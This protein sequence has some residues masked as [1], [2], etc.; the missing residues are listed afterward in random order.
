MA[1]Q[2]VWTLNG[3][4]GTLLLE[5]IGRNE[6]QVGLFS[7]ATRAG[8]LVLIPL[9]ALI[10]T[11]LPRLGP[12]AEGAEN[13][14]ARQKLYGH[15]TRQLTLFSVIVAL[16][17]I[18]F[19]E[20]VLGLFGSD[21]RTAGALLILTGISYLVTGCVGIAALFLQF[22]GHE[23]FSLSVVIGSTLLDVL[24]CLIL[25]PRFEAGGAATSF[26]VRGLLAD[27]ICVYALWRFQGLV[28]YVSRAPSWLPARR[29]KY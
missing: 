3:Y 7:A 22:C 23:R 29:P 17:I 4:S 15:A 21:Y 6:A 5:V 8:G 27:G 24:L 2:L 18:L 20:Q 26:L 10:A 25:V 9:I 14:D 16:P 13:H 19:R 28:P 12:I 1:S 11:I